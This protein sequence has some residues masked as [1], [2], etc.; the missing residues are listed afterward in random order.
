MKK[1]ND[2]LLYDAKKLCLDSLRMS[3]VDSKGNNNNYNK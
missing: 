2:L 1:D 3:K